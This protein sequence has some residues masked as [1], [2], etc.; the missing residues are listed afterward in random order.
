[1]V[2]V[3]DPGKRQRDPAVEKRTMRELD[4]L[5]AEKDSFFR[6]DPRSP[7]TRE[8][9]A[10]F[11][12]LSYFPENEALVIVRTPE[13][14]GVDR[15]ERIVMPTT[16]GGD[17]VYRRAG[18]VRF[19]VEGEPAQVTLFASTDTPE[20]FLPFR[21]AT[22]GKETY[23][24]GRYLDIEPP[25]AS[26]LI[27]I[28]FNV[29]HNPYCADYPDWSCPIPPAENCMSVPIRAGEKSFPGAFEVRA[30]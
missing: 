5:R 17:Q 14:G 28:D 19:E 4:E 29:S 9:R 11:D 10:S 24:A 21:D 12:H 22:S 15:N 25:G 7:L 2:E 16:T 8:Q 3:V 27:E 13:T 18:I 1:M 20:L 30:S 26:G 23:G 6:D